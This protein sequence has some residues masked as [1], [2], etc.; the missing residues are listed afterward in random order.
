MN[1]IE[2]LLQQILDSQNKTN[3]RLEKIE[4]KLD[5]IYN[6]TASTNET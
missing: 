3:E 6:Q 5:T 2:Q 4:N 1:N